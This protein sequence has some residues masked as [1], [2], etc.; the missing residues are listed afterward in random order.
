LLTLTNVCKNDIFPWIDGPSGPAGASSL[1]NFRE[2]T[3][4]TSTIGR[5]LDEGSAQRRDF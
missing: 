2:H 4:D 1:F 5:P 3:E